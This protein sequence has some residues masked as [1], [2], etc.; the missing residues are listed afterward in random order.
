M[1]EDRFPWDSI[2]R[3]GGGE[4]EEPPFIFRRKEGESF[5]KGFKERWDKIG[6]KTKWIVGIIII[7][8]VVLILSASWLSTFY[9]DYLWYKEV[10]KTSIFWKVI[11]TKIW[12]FFAFGLLFFA[13][14][15]GN[16]WMAR[17]FTPRYEKPA[18][19][20]SPI[21]ES[22]ARFREGAGHW[23]DRGI[24]VLC[25]IASFVVGWTSSSQWESVLRYFNHTKIGRASCRE[26][27]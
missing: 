10:G 15:Y 21:E 5:G 14:L 23:L 2:F 1:P 13:I 20:I 24:L 22:V 19:D 8:L 17:R 27:V 7:V 25:I 6:S 18:G 11:W 16:L 4:G 12:L 3:G 9:T 26:R